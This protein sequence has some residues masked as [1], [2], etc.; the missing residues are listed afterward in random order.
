MKTKDILFL[1][2]VSLFGCGYLSAQQSLF[3]YYKGNPIPL[4]VNSQHF[5]VYADANK[6]STELF[7][8]EFR[9]TEW[10]EDGSNGFL[11]AQINIPNENYDSVINV[12]KAKDC[13]IDIEPVIGDNEMINTSR[14]FYVKLQNFQD[15]PLLNSMALR[16]GSEIRGEV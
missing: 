6:I 9:I 8:K 4:N 15:Y 13:I 2:I 1:F 16:T 10:V 5:L 12:L 7:A 11:E 3:Y 14:V